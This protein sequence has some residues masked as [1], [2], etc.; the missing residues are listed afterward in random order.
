MYSAV[1]VLLPVQSLDIRN[2]K[3]DGKNI[4]GVERRKKKKSIQLESSKTNS[5]SAGGTSTRTLN[6]WVSWGTSSELD[7]LERVKKHHHS[8]Q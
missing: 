3:I 4:Y 7:P 1:P 8:V 6:F 2:L 5:C